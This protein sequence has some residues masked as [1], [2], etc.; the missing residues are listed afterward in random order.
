MTVLFLIAVQT[1]AVAQ[2][3]TNSRAG[4]NADAYRIA[5]TV[6]SKTDGHLLANARVTISDTKNLQKVEFVITSEDGKYEFKGLP[7]GKYS[8]TGRKRGFIPSAY[9]AHEQFSTA[10]VTGAG[11]D[12]E[13]LELK[14]APDAVVAGKVLDE[15]GEPVRGARVTVYYDDHGEG[16]SQ[17]HPFR[18]AQTDDLGVYEIT[19]LRPGTYFLSVS[20]KPWYAVHPFS[21]AANSEAKGRTDAGQTF[22]RSLDVAYPLTYYADVTEADSAQPILIRGGERLQ[23]D[24]HMNPLPA[25]RL[26]FRVPGDGSGRY[27]N[28]RIEQSA[29]GGATNAEVDS[30][31]MVSPGIW[32]MTGIPAG[33]YNIRTEGATG[34]GQL[35][36]VDLSKDGEEVDTSRAEALSNIRVHVDLPGEGSVPKELA[37][38]LRSGSRPLA[39]LSAIDSKGDAEI[40]N[41]P[42]GSYEWVVT[43]SRKRYSIAHVAAEGAEVS[44][45]VLVLTPG[46]SPSVS[47]TLAAGNVDV[48]GIAKKA[49]KGFA[50]AMVVLVPDNPKENRNLFRRDQSD[51]DGTFSLPSVI[52]GSYTVLAIENGWELNWSEPE[53]IAAYMKRGRKIEVGSKG[54]QVLRVPN[55]VEV[56]SQ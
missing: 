39:G 50:G 53:V 5:G 11:L 1:A 30:V 3:A 23:I 17:I 21:E 22:D 19:P 37:V 24:V 25:L 9:D 34:G 13:H 12:T 32:E 18:G 48:Q 14:L 2:A 41:V 52:P 56:Q 55:P 54:S 10:I 45:H 40:D 20:A 43:N 26:T 29:L 7:P 31:R 35:N 36:G 38:G 27:P 4:D 6:V 44:G 8:L 16:I 28:P 49:G 15:A 42:A 46:S 51:L 33:R 47:L